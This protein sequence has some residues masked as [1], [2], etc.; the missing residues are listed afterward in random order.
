MTAG[1]PTPWRPGQTELTGRGFARSFFSCV[2]KDVDQL[3]V[4]IHSIG[5]QPGSITAYFPVDF[6]WLDAPTLPGKTPI[7]VHA[8]RVNSVEV[9]STTPAS[10][11]TLKLGEWM[12]IRI[13]YS[14]NTRA[15]RLWY[16]PMSGGGNAMDESSGSDVYYPA[17]GYG[18]TDFSKFANQSQTDVDELEVKMVDCDTEVELARTSV[19]IEAHWR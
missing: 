17:S 16:S 5:T 6:H 18:E 15:V 4:E 3:K 14:F 13:R 2:D 7:V 19:H 11:A 8:G 9:V 12:T 1:L 10:P